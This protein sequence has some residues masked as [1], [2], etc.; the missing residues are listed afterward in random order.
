MFQFQETNVIKKESEK[1]IKYQD[2][3]VEIERVW[4]VTPVQTWLTGTISK[5]LKKIP[6]QHKKKARN[7]GTTENSHT[8]QGT[9]TSE[10][11]NVEVQ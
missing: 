10:N 6:E 5:S 3:T 7:R 8:G 11:T 2:L 1:I 4:N 9:C